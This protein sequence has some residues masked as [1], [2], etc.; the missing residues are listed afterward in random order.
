MIEVRQVDQYAEQTAQGTGSRSLEEMDIALCLN[1][2][3]KIGN[4]HGGDD[5]Q[6]VVGHLHVVGMHLEGRK[7][8]REQQA[9][10]VFATIGQHNARNH[11]RQ[12]GPGPHLP[13]VSSCN[14][15]EEIGA[16][17]P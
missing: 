6:I 7:E 13:D 8:G 2:L 9:P 11:R 1:G 12:V 3:N 15:D 5:K 4:D 10:Q 16:E 14:N 17:R